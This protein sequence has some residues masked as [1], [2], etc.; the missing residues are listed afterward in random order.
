MTEELQRMPRCNDNALF[1]MYTAYV[2]NTLRRLGAA[3]A[4][5]E[6]LTQDVFLQVHRHRGDHRAGSPVRPWLFAFAFR[7]ASQNRRRAYR[8]YETYGEIDNA[9]H[10]GARPD[11]EAAAAEDRALI[12][13]ALQALNMQ[14]RAV[15]VLYEIDR[16]AIGEIARSLGIPVNTAYSRLR[17][18]R[19]EFAVAVKRLRA[20]RGNTAPRP[21]DLRSTGSTSTSMT[22][23]GES[24]MKEPPKQLHLR[25][26]QAPSE[27]D[28]GPIAQDGSRA[29][30]H[31]P[32]RARSRQRR[33]PADDQR[34]GS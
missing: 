19:A 5:L 29:S 24:M 3:R 14:R 32:N 17:T 20:R 23:A 21:S 16:M 4:D 2:W 6:D 27:S 7:V 26:C 15:F 22:I 9:I 25:P 1:G 11:E 34:D 12:L 28:P 31:E 30:G 8:R 18:A 33:R 13:G 10:P